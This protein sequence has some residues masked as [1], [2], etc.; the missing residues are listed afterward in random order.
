MHQCLR[1]VE[2]VRLVVAEAINL[3]RPSALSLACTCRVLEAAVMEILWGSHQD[4]LVNLLRCFPAE[5]WEIRE[6]DSGKSYFVWT[7]I[8]LLCLPIRA[9]SCSFGG[10]I[11]L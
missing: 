9:N 8:S 11:G 5:V 10:L 7:R 3:E 4:D 1:V 2:I 6:S